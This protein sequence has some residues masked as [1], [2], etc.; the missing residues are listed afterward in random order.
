MRGSAGF[1]FRGWGPNKENN[2]EPIATRKIKE[3]VEISCVV[4]KDCSQRP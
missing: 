3:K 2:E 1:W 4:H